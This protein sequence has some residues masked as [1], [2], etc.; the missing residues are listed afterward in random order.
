MLALGHEDDSGRVK[1]KHNRKMFTREQKNKIDN[2]NV[3]LIFVA[4]LSFI[5]LKINK[6]YLKQ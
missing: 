5:S 1:P 4:I 2:C 6:K 3:E